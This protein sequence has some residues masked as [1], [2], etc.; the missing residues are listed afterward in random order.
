MSQVHVLWNKKDK[1]WLIKLDRFKGVYDSSF[2]KMI[3]KSRAR[4]LAKKLECEL[5]IHT[6]SGVIHQKY[7]Y[8]NDPRRSKG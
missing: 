4:E 7:S 5:S 1:R 8:G 3:A 6:Q 2:N